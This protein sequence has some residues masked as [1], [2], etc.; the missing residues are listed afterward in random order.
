ME[1]DCE[2]RYASCSELAADVERYLRDEP[3]VASPPILRYRTRKF[4][5]RNKVAVA[6]A[7]AVAAAPAAWGL[8]RGVHTAAMLLVMLPVALIVYKKV[9][10][11]FLR[12]GWINVDFLWAAGLFL[13]GGATIL[14]GAL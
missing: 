11:A 12:R 3:V 6:A 14:L 2:R 7:L 5:R 10:L 8:G 9:G 4:V 13:A 1:K